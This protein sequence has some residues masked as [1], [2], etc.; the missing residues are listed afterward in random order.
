MFKKPVCPHCRAIYDY[1]EINNQ[2]NNEEVKCH[3]CKKYFTVKKTKG[4]VI[5]MTMAVLFAI[6]FNIFLLTVINIK[7]IIPLFISAVLIIIIALFLKP[8]FVKYKGNTE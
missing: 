3:N 8:F 2:K 6:V 7:G 1:K 4:Y 5:L